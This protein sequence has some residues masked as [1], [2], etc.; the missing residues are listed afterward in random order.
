VLLPKDFLR[1]LLTGEHV[2]DMSDASGTLWLDVDRREWSQAL[3]T[4][5]GLT[6]GHMPR[7]VEGSDVSGT[8][9]AGPAASLGLPPG[10][11]VAGGGGDNAA[12]AVGIG[13]VAPGQAFVSLGTSGV[14][15][16]ADDRPLPDPDRTVHAFCHALPGCWHRMA[17][18]LS[19]AASLDWA[20]RATGADVPMLLAELEAAP[21]RDDRLV[22]L[23]YL[24]GERTPH[25]DPHASGVLFGITADTGRADITRAVLEGVAF[26]LADGLAALEAMGGPIRE[27][28]VIGGGAQSVAWGSILAAALD[29]PL[30]FHM[31]GEVGPALGAARL[32]QLAAGDGE[33]ATVCAPPPVERIVEPDASLAR[34]MAPRKKLFAS[35]YP[36][37]KPVFAASRAE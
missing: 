32:A 18:I 17:V 21:V 23:P 14:V 35:L 33:I 31:G 26:A 37:L 22:F 16:V 30:V 36:A 12:G 7:L 25:D 19:A 1:L 28:S 34:R 13:C 29:R 24:S 15:F 9:R 5:T 20:A 3:L 2:S 6:P 8:L 11:R 10:I 27:L 4:A